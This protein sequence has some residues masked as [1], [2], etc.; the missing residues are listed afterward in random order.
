MKITGCHSQ[1]VDSAAGARTHMAGALNRRV[2]TVVAG[3]P[4]TTAFVGLDTGE[5]DGDSWELENG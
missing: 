2:S 3:L 4:T 5:E 1:V